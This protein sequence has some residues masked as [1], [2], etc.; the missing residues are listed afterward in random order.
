[1][2]TFAVEPLTE[3]TARVLSA[4]GTPDDIAGKLARWLINANLSGHPSHG[5]IRISQYLAHIQ[6]GLYRP[7]ERPRVKSESPTSVVME[8]GGA[9]G[10][11]AAEE[12]TVRLVEKSRESRVAV[13]GI[14]NCNHIGR[15]GEWSELAVSMGAVYMIVAGGPG[16]MRT[17]P[18]GGREGRMSTNPISFGAPSGDTD[19]IILDFA[20]TGAAEGKIRVARDKG[21]EIPPNQ[22][23]DNQGQP[24]TNPNDLYDDGVM[25][26]FGGH[27]GYGLMLMIELLASNLVGDTITGSPQSPI[28]T[29]ALAIDPDALG[30]GDGF[31][32]MNDA[33]INRV[34]QT[35]PAPGFNE[36]LVPGD[37]ERRSRKAVRAA[38]VELP[39]ATWNDV[40]AAAS[41][42]GLDP[43]EVTAI[44]AGG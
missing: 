3:A 2:P 6:S 21:V 5:V 39:D 42:V 10:H 11:L 31:A 22:I 16:M 4:A 37:M 41:D 17:A 30:A 32:A 34:K 20:T 36:V 33:T 40:L 15:L 1:M 27:K 12:L 29:F 24:S 14:A 28:G 9:F 43:A 13:G 19:P 25:L 26:P 8:G 38:G 18:F 44:A 7:A 23:L 35:A